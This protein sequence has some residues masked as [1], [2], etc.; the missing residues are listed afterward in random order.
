MF[1]Y[2]LFSTYLFILST[3][4]WSLN[5]MAFWLRWLQCEAAFKLL[6]MLLL[7]MMQC[8]IPFGSNPT[9]FGGFI[10]LGFQKHIYP[11]FH[12]KIFTHFTLSFIDKWKVKVWKNQPIYLAL[13]IVCKTLALLSLWLVY[14]VFIKL[15]QLIWG[16]WFQICIHIFQIW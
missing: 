15:S 7:L 5:P 8:L 3:K 14:Y 11:H 1:F 9:S 16:L 12:Q 4:V 10:M 13:E 6:H 2:C